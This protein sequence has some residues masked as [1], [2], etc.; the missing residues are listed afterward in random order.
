M[1]T[2]PPGTLA[3]LLDGTVYKLA[4]LP[5]AIR[6]ILATLLTGLAAI[7]HNLLERHV[8]NL[9][10]YATFYPVVEFSAL[11]GGLTAGMLA[12]ISGAAVACLWFGAAVDVNF[13]LFVAGGA[14]FCVFADVIRSAWIDNARHRSP[15]DGRVS[16]STPQIIRATHEPP[17]TT[18][19][20][21]GA[22]AHEINQPLTATVTYLKV[23]Q[24]LLVKSGVAAPEIIE[25]LEKAKE[26]TLRAGRIVTSLRDLVQRRDIDKTL[27]EFNGLIDAAMKSPE[28]VSAGADASIMLHKGARLDLTLVDRELIRQAVVELACHALK[29]RRAGDV[30]R[31]VISTSNPDD[32]SIRVDV[33]DSGGDLSGSWVHDG[34]EPF[35]STNTSKLNAGLSLS[36]SFIEMHGGRMWAEPD[37]NDGAVFGF[38]LPLAQPDTDV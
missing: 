7:T 35:D 32:H 31:L 37:R 13:G 6:L 29:A 28:I 24:R 25:L 11:L 15:Q 26:Q 22:L 8:E 10:S 21:A 20:A 2:S 33:L 1:H 23:A 16:G 4:R 36:R 19:Q 18:G 38:V 17:D 27:V 3:H 12:T 34:N 30:R 14:F 5:L 9:S